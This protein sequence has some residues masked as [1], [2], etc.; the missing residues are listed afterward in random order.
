MVFVSMVCCGGRPSKLQ[1]KSFRLLPTS[2]AGCGTPAGAPV[3]LGHGRGGS[4]AHGAIFAS[5]RLLRKGVSEAVGHA[6]DMAAGIKSMRGASEEERGRSYIIYS[7]IL[8]YIY[9]II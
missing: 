3:K 7:Y 9:V 6:G 5:R 4:E 8:I 1:L 2:G